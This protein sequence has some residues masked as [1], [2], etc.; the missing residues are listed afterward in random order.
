MIIRSL[1]AGLLAVSL[2]ACGGS[3]G[4]EDEASAADEFE[5][6]YSGVEAYPVLASSE[7][8]VGPNRFV[9]GLLDDNDA[10]LADPQIKMTVDFYDISGAEPVKESSSQMDW[11]WIEEGLRG[12]YI[13]EA[14]FPEA[15]DWGVEIKVRGA[16]IDEQLRSKAAVAEEASTPALGEWPPQSDTPTL[17]DVD[18]LS[19][20]STDTTP[21]KRF[22]KYS[23]AE[24]FLQKRPTV[25]VFA[26][27]KFCTS[28]VC[29]PT[30]DRVQEVA[31]GFP[32]VTF[33]HV[34]PY[35]LDLLPDQFEPVRAMTQWKLPS[36]PWVFVMDGQ[37]RVVAK[38]EGVMGQ[39]ELREVL[40]QTA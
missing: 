19:E 27:P 16:G 8:V 34:E 6:S 36:E 26:T 18:S 2:A 20:I 1:V 31:K 11:V 17:D 35:E 3:G 7:L 25:V 37:G 30:L 38:Y 10:P 12:Y 24:A 9:V 39:D 32:E 28:A 40:R 13:G 29:A 14:T 5:Q 33:V 23:I 4:A 22:Y 21:V 15:G